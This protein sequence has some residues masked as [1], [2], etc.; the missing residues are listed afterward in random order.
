MLLLELH[1]FYH[2]IILF[3]NLLKSD[4]TLD[5]NSAEFLIKKWLISKHL[6][7]KER[8]EKEASMIDLFH[9]EFGKICHCCM[10]QLFFFYLN[11]LLFN[12]HFKITQTIMIRNVFGYLPKRM[13]SLHIFGTSITLCTSRS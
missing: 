1:T 4:V 3:K 12:I 10:Y 11:L 7:G 5:K 13:T 8:V 9:Q 6:V 2:L